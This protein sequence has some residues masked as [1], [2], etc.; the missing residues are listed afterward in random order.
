M[1]V[2]RH[3]AR[4]LRP[5]ALQLG[6]RR[7][8]PAPISLPADYVPTDYTSLPPEEPPK[9]GPINKAVVLIAALV[10]LGLIAAGLYLNTG[11]PPVDQ[12]P[13]PEISGTAQASLISSNDQLRARINATIQNAEGL[14]VTAELLE[15][16][17]PFRFWD[18][19]EA[20]KPVVNQKVAFELV[21]AEGHEPGREDSEYVVQLTV[22]SDPPVIITSTL[23]IRSQV[24]AQFAAGDEQEPTPTTAPLTETVTVVP[25]EPPAA[26]PPVATGPL[27]N[28]VITGAGI[29]YVSPFGPAGPNGNVASG[30]QANI[31]VKLPVDAETWYLTVVPATGVAGWVNSSLINLSEGEIAQIVPVSTDGTMAVVFNG[32]NLRAGPGGG[33]AKIGTVNAGENVTLTGRNADNSWFEVQAPAGT[34]WVA[35]SLLTIRPGVLEGIAVK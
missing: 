5:I 3:A 23:A 34:G 17:V 21:E 12:P 27:N 35:S 14:D 13:P 28:I 15:D 26:P 30:Q 25:T 24:M 22:Q 20:T 6:K 9:K 29:A 19:A 32:G 18:E 7:K 1:T 4:P 31:V 16:G 33:Q 2:A 10:V 11:D 8:D